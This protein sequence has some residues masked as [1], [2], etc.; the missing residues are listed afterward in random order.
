M[1]N[2]NKTK[3]EDYL[4]IHFEESQILRIICRILAI[5]CNIPCFI[6][7]FVFLF[8]KTELKLNQKI[9][10]RL[11]ITLVLYEASH[12]L[13]VTPEYQWMCYF[14][15][16]ISFGIEIIIS[17]YAMI[18]TY[19]ALIVFINS[20]LINNKFNKFLIHY[21]PLLFYIIIIAYILLVPDL[22]IYFKFTV[23]PFDD[24]SRLLNYSF[25]FLFLLL[26][27]LNNIILIQ[28]IKNFINKLP[29]VDNF[30]KE[31]YRIFKKKFY[32]NIIGYIF[33]FHYIL[34]VGF[35]TSFH[36]VS[37]KYFFNF[38]SFLYLYI[39]KAILGIVF[40]FIYIYN[41]NFL[42]K[43]LILT[44]IEKKEKYEVNFEKEE[45][46]MEYSID[47][48]TRINDSNINNDVF[49]II[50][51]DTNRTTLNSNYSNYEDEQL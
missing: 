20:E 14:Q 29:K 1:G 21:F 12:Y 31:K 30:A 9:Q 23:Y 37:W 4:E 42:H 11:C 38:P 40:W 10:L 41:I 48:S 15:C 19:A 43:F 26:N 7:I 50:P 16:I 44:R 39:N 49:E 45:K 33:V 32:L 51:C 47:T 22:Y 8:Q 28:K 34:L 17:Y 13:P 2:S 6:S 27:I 36:L 35:L 5:I 18:Y 24:P 3:I 46:I 25:V